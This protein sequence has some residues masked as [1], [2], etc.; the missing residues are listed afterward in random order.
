MSDDINPRYALYLKINPA[1][2][3]WQYINWMSEMASK[4]RQK[5]GVGRY[6]SI[7]RDAG[8][9]LFLRDD[10]RNKNMRNISTNT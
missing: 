1:P 10:V 5:L 6:Y 8:F 3:S 2:K 9:D 4:Y 7:S